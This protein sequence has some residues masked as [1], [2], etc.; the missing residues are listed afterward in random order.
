MSVGYIKYEHSYTTLPLPLPL[1][2]Q[3]VL[4]AQPRVPLPQPIVLAPH[5]V[6]LRRLLGDDP[7]VNLN[8]NLPQI[9]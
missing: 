4:P 3:P 5:V 9:S 6:D 1:L 7:L 8:L 2:L